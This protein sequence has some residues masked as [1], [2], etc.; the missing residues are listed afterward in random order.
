V[1]AVGEKAYAEGLGDN[2]APALPP[3]QQQ[4]IQA[5]QATGKPVIVVVLA[6]RPVGLGPAASANGVL[7][8]YQGGRRR[9]RLVADV[10]FGKVNPSGKLPVSW[11]SDAPAVGGDF[12]TTAPSPL[13][14]QPKFF[15]QLPSTA[16]GPG[17]GYNP[18]FPFGF[19]LSYTAFARSALSVPEQ[20]DAAGT[21][22][23]QLKVTN[24][25][26]RTG[27]DIVPL[28]VNQPV[29]DVVTPPQRL[30]GF[31]RVTLR[32]GR[33]EDGED[34]VRPVRAGRQRRDIDAAGPPVV[35]PGSY[36]AQVD[37]NTTTPYEV[38][39]SDT[40]TVALAGGTRRRTR[41]AAPTG[42]RG[43]PLPGRR[44]LHTPRRAGGPGDRW[45]GRLLAAPRVWASDRSPGLMLPVTVLS[46]GAWRRS[47]AGEEN[48]TAGGAA[49]RRRNT[50]RCAVTVYAR[51]VTYQ[52]RSGHGR[53]G[54]LPSSVTTPY[55]PILAM[56]R[57]IGMSAIAQ[58]ATGLCI[59]D[60]GLGV[61]GGHA[62]ERGQDPAH[63]R[64]H[65]QDPRGH[66]RDR[67]V[68]RRGDGP[69]VR[70]EDGGV[71]AGDLAACA[72]RGRR[73]VHRRLHGGQP[74]GA[75]G[76]PRPIAVPA[77]WSI[78][79]GAGLRSRSPTTAPR[80]PNGGWPARTDAISWDPT[81]SM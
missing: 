30:V 81:S 3:D 57:C 27:T 41:A 20:V 50:E 15:D 66:R 60:D 49:M 42:C 2:P 1:V 23:A 17:S 8:A 61:A 51:T 79:S 21:V 14:D 11:P 33:V 62:R 65:R 6:G 16:S 63:P 80:R 4:L 28:Y 75:A 13:G 39:V 78:R 19:G 22:T 40:F 34:Q 44:S 55:R 70:L 29:S 9:A 37:K 45:A 69:A 73:H 7:M 31:T 5:L 59:R 38:E 74:S 26:A 67:G 71:C 12:Q 48:G 18:Q 68:A 58:R 76:D 77:C 56:P 36:I 10:L 53:P 24:T 54:A 32:A 43:L 52:G 72:A 47:R 46:G 25:G 35:Q 64:S